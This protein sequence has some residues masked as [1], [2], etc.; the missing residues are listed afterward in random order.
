MTWLLGAC[1]ARFNREHKLFGRLF[2]GRD[3]SLL[4]DHSGNGYLKT[5]CHYMHLKKW[6]CDRLEMGSWKSVNRRL[7]E[8]G[9]TKC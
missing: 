3:K 4:L 5:V 9:K 7:Y 6:I 8:I 1:T 2:S